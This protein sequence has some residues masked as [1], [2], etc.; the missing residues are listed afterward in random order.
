[1][2]RRFMLWA[3]VVLLVAAGLRLLG[4]EEVPPGLS[5][6]EIL[7]ADIA[8]FIRQGYRAIF[9]REGYGHEP[10][11]HYLAAPFQA[12]W[13]DNI[14]SIR[15]TAGYLGLLVVALTMRW[16]GQTFGRRSALLAGAWLAIS[17]W[18]I[19]FSRIGLRPILLPVVL[20]LAML[21]WPWPQDSNPAG[22]RRRAILSGGLLGLSLYTYTAA[23]VV[24]LI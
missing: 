14:L 10:L 21:Y 2:R 7:D 6:D 4:L 12:L 24:F 11:F 3:T 20:L 17:W 16:A 18:P 19:I 5:Q 9:F 15:V 22:M 1:A 8:F 13:G 23:Q